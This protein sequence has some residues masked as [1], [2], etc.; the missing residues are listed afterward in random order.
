VDSFDEIGDRV[1]LE[2][3]VQILVWQPDAGAER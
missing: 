1:L 3:D 2:R